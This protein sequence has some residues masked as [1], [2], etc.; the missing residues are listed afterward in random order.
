MPHRLPITPSTKPVMTVF[1]RAI[2]AKRLVYLICTPRPQKYDRGRSRIVYIGTTGIGVRRVA[3]SMAGKAIKFLTHHGVKYLDVFTITCPPRP[4]TRSWTHL[5]R[6]LLIAFKFEFG[7][8]PAANTSG[9][10]LSPDKL[11]GLF[12]YRRLLKVLRARG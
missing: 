2:R 12:Q 9:K 5:E 1:R 6:D 8:V 3:A 7:S 4:G 11:S 10:N